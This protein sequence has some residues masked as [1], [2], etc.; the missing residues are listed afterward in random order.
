MKSTSR[1]KLASVLL[2]AGL[3]LSATLAAVPA[4]ASPGGGF[5]P[6]MGMREMTPEMQER[7]RDRMQARLDK[8]AERLEI[9]AS[10]QDAWQ[11]YVKTHKEQFDF[12][13]LKPAPKEADA[14]TLARHR[15]EMAAQMAKKLDTLA[16]ATARLQS[17]L[18]PEQAKTLA[19]M[20]RHPMGERHGKH[21]GFG[22]G[23]DGPRAQMGGMG[24]VGGMR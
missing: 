7:M 5:G 16:D 3:A 19:E 20:T 14:A 6:G 23:G 2:A 4:A 10:Q 21:G 1:S 9:K 8:M 11:A 13:A 15:A 12:A 18:T 22:R 24:G 17:A